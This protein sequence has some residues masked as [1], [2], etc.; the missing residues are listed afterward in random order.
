MA[1]TRTVTGTIHDP[2]GQ[3]WPDCV[4]TFTLTPSRVTAHATLPYRAVTA[5][6]D[7]TGAFSVELEVGVTYQVTETSALLASGSTVRYPPG[8]RYEIVVPEGNTPISI[9]TIRA[10]QIPVPDDPTLINMVAQLAAD[11][12]AALSLV[13]MQAFIDGGSPSSI[14]GDIYLDGG[15]P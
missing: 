8:T 1:H 5:T 6:T 13:G 7:E 9:E 3:P 10:A 14:Y 4:L 2:H 12:D 11:L 15:T